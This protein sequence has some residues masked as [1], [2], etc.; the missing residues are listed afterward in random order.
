[1]AAWCVA[2]ERVLALVQ[3]VGNGVAEGGDRGHPGPDSNG[4]CAPNKQTLTCDPDG[5]VTDLE[6]GWVATTRTPLS[7]GSPKREHCRGAVGDDGGLNRENGR[8]TQPNC[9]RHPC[10]TNLRG[11]ASTLRGRRCVHPSGDW[12]TAHDAQVATV[13]DGA[14]WVPSRWDSDVS[15]GA[16]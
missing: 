11:K 5:A 2:V 3:S 9:A 6:R 10:R 15:Q 13:I 8:R 12:E 7:M 1:M 16:R 14:L 4:R